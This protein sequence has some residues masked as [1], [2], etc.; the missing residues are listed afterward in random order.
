MKRGIGLKLILSVILIV[1]IIIAGAGYVYLKTDM[2][3]PTEELFYKYALSSFEGINNSETSKD[4]EYTKYKVSGEITAETNN[5]DYSDIID[6]LKLSYNGENDN[7]L[8]QY[9]GEY[10]FNSENDDIIKVKFLKDGQ[11]FGIKSDEVITKYISVENKNL[12]SLA[13]KFGV[14]DTSEIP[15]KFDFQNLGNNLTEEQVKSIINKYG[16]I[17]RAQISTDKYSKQKDVVT[18][19]NG[20]EKTVNSYT[21]ILN[22]QDIYNIELNVL[23]SLKN[24]DEILS[25]VANTVDAKDGIIKSIDDEIEKLQ[26]NPEQSQEEAC[27]IIVYESL[28]ETVKI[29]LLLKEA[30]I[31]IEKVDIANG[32]QINVKIVPIQDEDAII[33]TISEMNIVISKVSVGSEKEEIVKISAARE[34][35]SMSLEIKAKET[36]ESEQINREY[37]ISIVLNENVSTN[38]VVMNL[39]DEEM[40]MVLNIK[41]TIT[42]KDST[43][44]EKLTTENSLKINDLTEEQIQSL[45]TILNNQITNVYNEKRVKFGFN[46]ISQITAQ[47]KLEDALDRIKTNSLVDSES[48]IIKEGKL[49]LSDALAEKLKMESDIADAAYYEAQNTMLVLV[50]ENIFVLDKDLKISI[51]NQ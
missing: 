43:N 44:I 15:D 32:K 23:A 3:R 25:L 30:T 14:T 20:T 13:E 8:E 26:K 22:K 4:I 37:K 47:N 48:A 27:K 45:I 29:E 49:V 10:T 36:R 33:K 6:K 18:N 39:E 9:Y 7:E 34:N 16:E 42:P 2:L 46:S 41:E 5:K 38:D 24:D 17:A 21:L 19:V 12:K 51:Y 28:G 50:D 11:T 35:T 31:S 1:L 40:K